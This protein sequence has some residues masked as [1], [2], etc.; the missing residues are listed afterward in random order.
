[1]LLFCFVLVLRVCLLQRLRYAENNLIYIIDHTRIN[2]VYAK[3]INTAISIRGQ[4][5]P[6]FHTKKT[7]LW[8][9]S[10]HLFHYIYVHALT[11]INVVA[12]LNI[13]EDTTVSECLQCFNNI[14]VIFF[15]STGIM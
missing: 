10:V 9:I 2:Y 12:F 15:W 3:H 4:I 14:L 1:M 7:I 6:F 8:R 11:A 13:C 5:G